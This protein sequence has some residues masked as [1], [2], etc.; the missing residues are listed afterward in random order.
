MNDGCIFL[1]MEDYLAQWF[2]HAN[3]GESPVRLIRG[4][5]ESNILELFLQKIPRGLEPQTEA[6]EGQ[7]AIR[8]P[9]FK[10]KDPAYYRYLGPKGRNALTTCIR[11]RFDVEL[12]KDLHKVGVVSTKRQDQ[13]IYAWME[14]HGIELEEKNWCAIAKRYQRKRNIYLSSKKVK[15]G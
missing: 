8:I 13:V 12:W 9:V 1:D 3:G 11:N 14:M 5:V 6:K 10:S 2:I 15:K 4:S 7:V